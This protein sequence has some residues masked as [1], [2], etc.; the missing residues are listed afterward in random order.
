MIRETKIRKP[1]VYI[2]V[3]I[4]LAILLSAFLIMLSALGVT[5]SAMRAVEIVAMIL[6]VHYVNA[7]IFS[8]TIPASRLWQYTVLSVLATVVL[9]SIR[10]VIDFRPLPLQSIL[11]PGQSGDVHWGFFLLSTGSV[12]L[13]S[14]VVL[15]LLRAGEN[16]KR[17]LRIIHSANEA[18]L[19]YLD[20][21]IK[22]HFLF[23]AL[24]NVYSHVLIKSDKAPEMLLSLTSMLRY[25][26][27]QKP[28]EK[29]PVGEEAAQI[30]RLIQLF[31]LK[32]D[33]QYDIIFT[34]EITGGVIEPMILVPLA[35]NCLKH[36]D[37]D[38]NAGAFVK[39]DLMTN[40]SG[41]HF[42]SENTYRKKKTQGDGGVGLR[43]IEER[44][45]LLYGERFKLE[46]SG[47][48][49]LFRVQLKI[50]WPE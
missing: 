35:E 44:L 7:G 4:W 31:S 45:Q 12:Y 16:E 28:M 39:I 20:A 48:E 29:V 42:H 2:H 8:F 27:Y 25:S 32:S 13:M 18:K 47:D 3:L 14:S 19:Q 15:F 50:E 37:F 1:N 41:L 33:D 5:Q 10:Y 26:I 9:S 21:Q 34:T 40:R 24:N 17:L 38:L 49:K 23:N 46:V 30:T 43:N 11:F 36:C 6:I 22:P